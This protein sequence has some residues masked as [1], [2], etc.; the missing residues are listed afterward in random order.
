MEPG[1]GTMCLELGDSFKDEAVIASELFYCHAIINFVPA[2]MKPCKP[3]H[4]GTV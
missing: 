4:T 2:Q 3:H 1:N